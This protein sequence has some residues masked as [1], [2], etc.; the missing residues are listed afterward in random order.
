MIHKKRSPLN[1]IL[2]KTTISIFGLRLMV[3]NRSKLS[4]TFWHR[5]IVQGCFRQKLIVLPISRTFGLDQM[6][7]WPNIPWIK[8]LIDVL[9]WIKC[10]CC[11]VVQLC[12]GLCN[13][14]DCSMPGFSVH[15]CLRSLLKLMSIES[16][17][18]SNHLILC[19]PLLLP[20]NFPST[21]VFSNDRIHLIKW[22]KYW[23]SN[24]S[25]S[26][27]YSGLIS[28]RIDWF[29]LLA[30]QWTLKSLPQHHSSK[31]SVLQGSAFLMVQLSHAYMTNGKTITLTICT[32][33]GKVMPLLSN[34]LSREFPMHEI[35]KFLSYLEF[36]IWIIILK[37][38]TCLY[39]MWFA[40]S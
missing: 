19:C 35:F 24:N 10:L 39:T 27:E 4:R 15:C 38:L 3:L 23:S 12:P 7:Y 8:C 37:V 25:P 2:S 32:F 36:Q 22:P 26:N 18:P 1:L 30:V 28:F 31:A 33:V 21:G 17:M 40:H 5:W 13:S 20:S 6:P 14:M 34:P 9:E 11:S 29:D 16:V